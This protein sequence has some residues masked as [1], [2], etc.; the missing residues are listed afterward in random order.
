MAVLCEVDT[1]AVAWLKGFF[2]VCFNTVCLLEQIQANSKIGRRHIGF[3]GT[4]SPYAPTVNV[5]MPVVHLLKLLES[6][7]WHVKKNLKD[8]FK[9]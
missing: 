2:V 5:P 3:L 6:K 8:V 7:L 9:K 4:P 1:Q